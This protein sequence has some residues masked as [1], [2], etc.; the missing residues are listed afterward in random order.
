MVSVTL[1]V[2]KEI[3]ELMNKFSEINW[4]A[5]IRKSIE[6]KVKELTW[7]EEMMQKL[8]QE[9]SFTNWAVEK[10]REM[11]QQRLSYLEKKGLI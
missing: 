6:T 1:S 8:K 10:Q 4:S 11:R 3:R 7:K 9:E 2:S 5:F